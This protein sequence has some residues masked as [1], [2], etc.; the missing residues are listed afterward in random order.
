MH[1]DVDA[2]RGMRN[3]ALT[4]KTHVVLCGGSK[5]LVVSKPGVKIRARQGGKAARPQVGRKAE[6]DSTGRPIE[7]C[8]TPTVLLSIKNVKAFLGFYHSSSRCLP[9]SARTAPDKSP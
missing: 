8:V 3:P 5:G 6:P 9:P 4:A 2:S 1:L 7:P